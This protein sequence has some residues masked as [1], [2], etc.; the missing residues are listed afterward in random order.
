[1]AQTPYNS[2]KSEDILAGHISGLQTDI[3]KI[4]NVLNMKTGTRSGHKLNPV[5]DQDDPALRYRIYE[6]TERNWLDTP[7]PVIYRNG[8]VVDTSEYILQAPYGVVVFHEQ[9]NSTDNITADFTYVLGASTKIETIDNNISTVNQQISQLDAEISVQADQ[10]ASKVSRTE[11]DSLQIGGRNL[12]RLDVS[13]YTKNGITVTNNNGTITLD[14]TSSARADIWL[15]VAR[16]DLIDISKAGK[17]YAGETYTLSTNIISGNTSDTLVVR[18]SFLDREDNFD[19]NYMSCSPEN[20]STKVATEDGYIIAYRVLVDKSGVVFDNLKLNV[21][22]E[23]GNKA[24]DWT[25]APE[26]VQGQIDGLD[27]RVTN[28]EKSGGGATLDGVVPFYNV[29]SGS[30]IS[31]MRQDYNPWIGSKDDTTGD[32]VTNYDPNTHIP[33]FNILVNGGTMDA[34]PLPISKGITISQAAIMLGSATPYA[35][36]TKIGLYKDNG[37]MYPGELVFS[38]HDIIT[39]PG[40]WGTME[41][42]VTIP[43]GLYWIVRLDKSNCYY[44]GLSRESA[45]SINKFDAVTFLQELADRPNPHTSYGG[46]RATDVAWT[47]DTSL[48]ETFPSG[49]GLFSREFYCS[50]WLVVG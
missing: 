3:N 36:R 6:A 42:N 43:P 28:L 13:N 22:L 24:T 23:K 2:L 11:F 27:T 18:A 10:I 1:M 15:T 17:I 46:Y 29:L 32:W 8:V 44:N 38:A 4:Q 33:A 14:G 48:P 45:L 49:V 41:V 25:P 35:V 30:Y 7:A 26:D 21:K 39:N 31:H 5:A 34:F 50:P 12:A 37:N 16:S 19:W 9:Q 20:A 47:D 40:E